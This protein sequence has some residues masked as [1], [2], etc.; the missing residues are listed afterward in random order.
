MIQNQA[1]VFC[2]C[3]TFKTCGRSVLN[4]SSPGFSATAD[5]QVCRLRRVQ[6]R[7]RSFRMRSSPAMGEAKHFLFSALI[8]S[9][10]SPDQS[11]N[12]TR[13][14]SGLPAIPPFTKSENVTMTMI[15]Q[16]TGTNSESVLRTST[17]EAF[18][19][20]LRAIWL[21]SVRTHIPVA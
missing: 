9:S 10:E 6:R 2:L 1:H 17:E 4:P 8:A 12:I 7:R 18:Y 5:G 21:V 15:A 13:L 11:V 19:G 14:A 16:L 3:H 20:L